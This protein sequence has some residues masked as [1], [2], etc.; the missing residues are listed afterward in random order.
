MAVVGFLIKN[1]TA[2]PIGE[3]IPILRSSPHLPP[4]SPLPEYNSDPPTSGL[5]YFNPLPEGFYDETSPE[6]ITLPNPEGHIVHSMEHGYA[7]FWYNCTI[8]SS[9]E[10]AD[11]K[12]Q[13]RANMDKVDNFKVIAFP[14]DSI[15]SPVVATSWG[16]LL[17]METFDPE[18]ASQFIQ[19]NRNNAPESNTR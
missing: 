14:R 5:H 6:V 16:R 18:L 9:E 12:G 13:I 19:R 2:P 17:E 7:V 8:L 15:N 3:Q 10:C 4:E 1:T 11:L